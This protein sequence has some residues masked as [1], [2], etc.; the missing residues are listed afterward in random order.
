MSHRLRLDNWAIEAAR[1][2]KDIEDSGGCDP[3]SS[4]IF[5]I[6]VFITFLWLTPRLDTLPNHGLAVT[7]RYLA[8]Y[9]IILAL[10]IL[11]VTGFG[12]SKP[13]SICKFK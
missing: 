13:R 3:S 10:L 5:A 4:F 6:S 12:I 8:I 7:L 1:V 9:L 2:T 11:Y